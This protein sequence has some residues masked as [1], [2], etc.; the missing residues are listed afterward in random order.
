M[1]K[2]VFVGVIGANGSGKSLF[3]DVLKG[4]GFVAV[5]LSD[6]VRSYVASQQLPADRDTLTEQA[7]RLKEKFGL[8]YFAKTCLDQVRQEAYIRVV[9]D[10]IRHPDEAAYLKQ[11][12]VFLVGLK[13]AASC[14]YD[15][16]KLRQKETDFVDEATFLRQD[17]YEYSGD[18]LGQSIQT[19]FDYCDVV[20]HN[21][22]TL[23]D[24][25]RAIDRDVLQQV[26]V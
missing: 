19:C 20:I 14:R 9:F 6:V 8:R 24:F 7:N 26:L 4:T 13:A 21:D 11:Q 25:E 23:D 17:A 16:I 3:C 5:S 10:S 18:S 12:G 22:G 2:T 1:K 15:R